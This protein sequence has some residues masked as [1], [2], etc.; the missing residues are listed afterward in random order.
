MKKRKPIDVLGII[1]NFQK[2]VLG[3]KPSRNQMADDVRMMKFKI[4]PLQGDVS[5][6]NL[7]DSTLIEMLWNLGK[8]EE[9][10]SQQSRGLNFN[11]REIFLRFFDNMYGQFQ[12]QLNKINLRSKT[13][14]ASSTIEM[15]IFKEDP[16]GKKKLN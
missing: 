16:S 4:R 13:E 12:D 14:K 7:N 9:F 10:Y 11:Q 5:L 6:L 8:L 3:N 15:E 1:A 2:D